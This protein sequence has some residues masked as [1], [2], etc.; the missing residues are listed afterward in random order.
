ML[1]SKSRTVITSFQPLPLEKYKYNFCCKTQRKPVLYCARSLMAETK[2][3]GSRWQTASRPEWELAGRREAVLRPLA[4]TTLLSPVEVDTAAVNKSDG[5]TADQRRQRFV[6][7]PRGKSMSP[8]DDSSPG[9]SFLNEPSAGAVPNGRP[10][11]R[12][13]R[14]PH[15]DPP[16]SGY[17]PS[18]KADERRLRGWAQRS[19]RWGC[20]RS[21]SR[22]TAAL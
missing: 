8:C 19:R 16:L 1:Q 14:A 3:K 5:H 2:P 15:A 22:P 20:K 4:E 9:L 7:L 10:S 11:R 12:V 18:F 6:S 21:R 13:A 17:I